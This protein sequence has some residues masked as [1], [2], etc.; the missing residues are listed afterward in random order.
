VNIYV[1]RK[2]CFFYSLINK[3]AG[4]CQAHKVG[5]FDQPIVQDIS[6]KVLNI[7]YRDRIG[8]GFFHIGYRISGIHA[9]IGRSY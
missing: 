7:R 5:Y 1:N 9:H 3:S 2:L 4:F 6:T 8:L